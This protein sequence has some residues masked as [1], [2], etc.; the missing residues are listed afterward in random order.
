M[1]LHVL[2]DLHIEFG[3]FNPPATCADVVILAGDVHV[4][5]KGVAWAADTFKDNPVIYVIGNHEYY[6]GA[7]PDV[8]NKIRTRAAGTNVHLLENDE[9]II[10]NV[11]FLGCTL[12][13]DFQLLNNFERSLFKAQTRMN[14]FRLVHLTRFNRILDPLDTKRWHQASKKWLWERLTPKS[15]NTLKNVVITHHAPS[16]RSVPKIYQ[17][18]ALSPAFASDLE[19]FISDLPIEM[20]VHGHIHDSFDYHIGEARIVCNPRGYVAYEPNEGFEAKLVVEV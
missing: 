14:D 18:D 5:D 16:A 15:N 1:K 9:L 10:G 4:G 19:A 13:T 20:W 7:V 12:W 3:D 2:S 17:T 6:H 11:R 8:T